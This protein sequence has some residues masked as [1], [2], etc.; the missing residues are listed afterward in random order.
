M[1]TKPFGD[2]GQ[3]IWGRT[4][5]GTQRPAIHYHSMRD[6][7]D[8]PVFTHFKKEAKKNVRKEARPQNTVSRPQNIQFNWF[9][10]E[11]ATN[12]PVGSGGAEPI[13]FTR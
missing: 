5:F 8:V 3:A 12:Y 11:G 2:G 7:G 13:K 9:I 10:K 6:N 1:G 4:F